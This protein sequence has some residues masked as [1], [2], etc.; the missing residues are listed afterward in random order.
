MARFVPNPR[1]EQQVSKSREMKRALRE[2]TEPA[3]R[4]AQRLAPVDTGEYRDSLQIVEDANGVR[5]MSDDDKASYIEFGTSDT[6]AFAPL[7]K[8]TEAAG[9]RTGRRR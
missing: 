2:A 1:F 8:G 3:L 9:L 4:E 5:L 7:R 6:P